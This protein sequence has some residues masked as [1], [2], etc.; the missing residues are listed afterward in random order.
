MKFARHVVRCRRN[1][2]NRR[3][4]QHKL[5]VTVTKQIS[6]VRMT[7]G[8]LFELDRGSL[9]ELWKSI[10]EIV[11]QRFKIQLF[12]RSEGNAVFVGNHFLETQTVSLDLALRTR[13]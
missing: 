1:R 10:A 11:A 7:T 4:P 13:R 2:T 12:A 6:K 3:A 5:V 8:K 9:I